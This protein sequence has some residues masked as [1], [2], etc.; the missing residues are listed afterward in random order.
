MSSAACVMGV[1]SG[2]ITAFSLIMYTIIIQMVIPQM[3]Q[4]LED[5]SPA[6][7]SKCLATA[8]FVLFFFFGATM[9]AGYVAFGAKV[10]SNVMKEL[11]HDTLGN[12]ANVM[13]AL[14]IVGCY[15]LNVKPMVAPLLR[16]APEQKESGKEALLG[17][18]VE[19]PRRGKLF[20]IMAILVA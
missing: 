8:L 15:P 1:S 17:S 20:E 4:E 2:T 19:S 3:Y 11:P 12:L 7:F 9:V 5:R 16:S 18:D 10:D 6:K 14:C 13:M